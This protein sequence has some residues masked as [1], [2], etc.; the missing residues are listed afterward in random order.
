[1]IAK[2]LEI[3][4]QRINPLRRDNAGIYDLQPGIALHVELFDRVTTLTES[5]LD[6]Q[7]SKHSLLTLSNWLCQIRST[8]VW[9]LS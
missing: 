6:Q 8:L 4:R 3:V 5:Q 7:V 1:M 9:T 2:T